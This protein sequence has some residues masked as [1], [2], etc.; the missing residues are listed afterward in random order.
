MGTH[1]RLRLISCGRGR[2]LLINSAREQPR[3][4]AGGPHGGRWRKS[5]GGSSAG[6]AGGGASGKSQD[7]G[8][9]AEPPPI[10]SRASSAVYLGRAKAR[11][12]TDSG[13]VYWEGE[14]LEF[15][16]N[17][18]GDWVVQSERK[19]RPTVLSTAEAQRLIAS[20]RDSTTNRPLVALG[21]GAAIRRSAYEFDRDLRRGGQKP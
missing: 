11:F 1:M 10:G 19:R 20:L 14:N 13:E 3:E 21:S 15:F 16:K 4:P 18:D 12:T 6:G 8:K 17:Q 2:R 5:G 9:Q 7:A